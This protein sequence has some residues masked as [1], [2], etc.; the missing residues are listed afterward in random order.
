MHM[1]NEPEQR[2]INAQSQAGKALQCILHLY[3]WILQNNDI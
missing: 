1:D 2:K 3:A